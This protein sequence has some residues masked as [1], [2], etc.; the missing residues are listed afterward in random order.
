M[1]TKRINRALFVTPSAPYRR[2]LCRLALLASPH[3]SQFVEVSSDTASS[4][5][6]RHDSSAT[7]PT[8]VTV[9][10]L[11]GRWLRH[12]DDRTPSRS[13]PGADIRWSCFAPLPPTLASGTTFRLAPSFSSARD[14]LGT[15]CRELRRHGSPGLHANLAQEFMSFYSYRKATMGSTFE[16]RRAG[17]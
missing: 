11:T 12:R 15:P 6:F 16:A 3:E 7:R 9:W 2:S 10:I 17:R 4:T 5:A 14:A 1:R 8:T 13:A